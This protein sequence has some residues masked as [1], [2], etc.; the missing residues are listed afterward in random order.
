MFS[1]PVIF[2]CLVIGIDIKP[3]TAAGGAGA[4]GGYS[5]FKPLFIYR[6]YVW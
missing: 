4:A 5:V 1:S 3:V 6:V 2:V